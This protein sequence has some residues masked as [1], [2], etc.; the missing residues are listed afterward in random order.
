MFLVHELHYN[1][2]CAQLGSFLT[3]VIR[4]RYRCFGRVGCEY[5]QN[6]RRILF[7]VADIKILNFARLFELR[8]RLDKVMVFYV[9]EFFNPWHNIKLLCFLN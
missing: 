5:T 6:L 8:R 4:L 9:K 1:T 7:G 2:P 3:L